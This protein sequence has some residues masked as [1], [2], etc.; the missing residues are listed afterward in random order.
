MDQKSKRAKEITLGLQGADEG[1]C[2]HNEGGDEGQDPQHFGA[3][4]MPFIGERRKIS[5]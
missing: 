2:G 4:G 3:C 5:G 1:G